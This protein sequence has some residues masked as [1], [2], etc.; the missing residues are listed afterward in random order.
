MTDLTPFKPRP[1]RITLAPVDSDLTRDTAR[2]RLALTDTP[3]MACELGRAASLSPSRAYAVLQTMVVK[4]ECV[5]VHDGRTGLG[6]MRYARLPTPQVQ[7]ARTTDTPQ[8]A[9][10]YQLDRLRDLSQRIRDRQTDAT[11]QQ[12]NRLACTLDMLETLT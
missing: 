4:G 3:Q 6:P 7:A 11:W 9:Y 2:L 12:V 10:R 5:R 8:Q 1:R